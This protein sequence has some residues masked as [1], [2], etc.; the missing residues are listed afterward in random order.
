MMANKITDVEVNIGDRFPLTIR[1][2]GVN[3]HGIGYYK[4]KVCFVPGALPGEV[5]VAEVTHVHPR[6]LEAKIHRLRKKSKHRVTPR[7]PYADV[8][9]GFELENLAY[10]QQLA[11]K[12][13]VILDSLEKFKPYGYRNYEVRKT[14]AAPEEYHY[15][16]KAQFQVRMVDGH[17][18]AGLYKP[19]S[20][21]LVDMRE[22]AVQMPRTMKVV[23]TVVQLIEELQIPVY[24]E[25]HNSGIIKTI[26][27][28][29]SWTT[30][31]LQL[32]LITNT[33]KLIHKRPLL[34]AITDQLPEVVSV[35]Q[36]VNPGDTPLVWGDQMI[37]LAGKETITESLMGLDFALSA[38][39]FLQLNPEQTEVLY[40]QAAQALELDKED[41]LID[42]YAGIGTIGLSLA[43]RVKAVRGM[44]IIPEAVANASDNA[45]LNG[46][47][48][49]HYEVGKA[50]DVIPKWLAE[51]LTF[52]ALVVDPPRAG[53]DDELIKQILRVKPRK[54]AYVSCGMASL[55]RNLRRLTSVYHVDYIQPVDMMPQTARCEA[56]VKLSRRR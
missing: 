48:N 22:C 30:G 4:H 2:L 20:H 1:R 6:F 14:I 56:V 41:T 44:E 10:P 47:D 11:F 34:S 38:R 12:R 45:R 40:E 55:A 19:N 16:N 5:V 17:V 15:R 3:G 33:P 50:E 26:V 18:A 51:G 37:H 54:F 42:A 35:M 24:D 23:R 43:P 53:L 25:D 52:D 46:I 28:R 8:A 39:S 29:E 7:D 27:V 21:D 9:G 32:T 31:E 13:Q 36:N 49:A